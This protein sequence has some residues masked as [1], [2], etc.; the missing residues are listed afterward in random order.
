MISLFILYYLFLQLCSFKPLRLL[1][2]ARVCDLV[3]QLSL[4]LY[5]FLQIQSHPFCL[6]LWNLKLLLKQTEKETHPLENINKQ[7]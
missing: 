7:K 2:C 5:S 4:F 1:V 6:L 3:F